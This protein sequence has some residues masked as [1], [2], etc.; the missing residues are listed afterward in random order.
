VLVQ[1]HRAVEA[2]PWFE[3]ALAG[4]P[5]FAEARLNLGIAYQESGNAA[6]AAEQYRRIL[7]SSPTGSREYQAAAKLLKTVG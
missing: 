3:R 1:G 7:D 2:I 4:S 6:K 5:G